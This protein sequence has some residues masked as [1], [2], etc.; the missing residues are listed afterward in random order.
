MDAAFLIGAALS[1]VSAL[2]WLAIDVA[3]PLENENAPPNLADG[4]AGIRAL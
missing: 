2:A 1:V 4:T 3:G